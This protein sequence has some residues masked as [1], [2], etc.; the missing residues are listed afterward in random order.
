MLTRLLGGLLSPGGNRGGLSILIF[1]RVHPVPDPLFPG[2][3]DASRF[4]ALLEWLVSSFSVLPL[5]QAITCLR[6]GT[7]PPRALSITFDDGYADNF[8][9]ALPLL[10]K[11][12]LNATF[13]ISTGALDG[14]CM[15]NDVVI[16]IIRRAEP[17][18]IDLR[19]LGLDLHPLRTIADRRAAID[20]LLAKLKYVQFDER[21]EKVAAL[22][23]WYG[24]ELPDNLMM[25][26]SQLRAMHAAG[27]GVGG[28]SQ[29][30]PILAEL[31]DKR[32]LDEI[33]G[34]KRDLETIIGH[35]VSL[36]AYPNGKPGRDYANRHVD[37]VRRA[38]YVGAVSTS[39]GMARCGTDLYQLPRFTPWD[40]SLLR[41]GLRLVDN[42]RL[43]GEVAV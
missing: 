38:G 15:W 39:P 26:S 32:A 22:A 13:F 33:A 37:M 11:H 25:T 7:L 34:G 20:G 35:R 29:H 36:F 19:H 41:F 5:D 9:V 2:E 21:T 12:G 3:T 8:T 31:D 14:G 4:E 43:P 42:M 28:H 10:Q 1:H 6:A 24:R 40:R 30:H 17:E 18:L 23:E 16:E 27:M